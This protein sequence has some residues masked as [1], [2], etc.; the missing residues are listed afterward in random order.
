MGLPG[1]VPAAQPRE[2]RREGRARHDR[3]AETEAAIRR[4]D[5][6]AEYNKLKAIDEGRPLDEAKG[7]GLW[8]AKVVASRR[9][10][11]SYAPPPPRGGAPAKGG[12]EPD[13]ERD[14]RHEPR[15][16]FR[17]LSGEEQTDE[18]FDREVVSRMGTQF[19]EEV[20]APAIARR[21]K[22]GAAYESIRDS[23]RR[24]WKS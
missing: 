1:T 12:H 17:T 9:F 20:F 8:I 2:T 15:E 16:K 11:P 24:G 6:F 22:K 21:F 4:F 10:G 13:T 19:Y 7:H 3:R 5:V 23:I 14:E 18:L